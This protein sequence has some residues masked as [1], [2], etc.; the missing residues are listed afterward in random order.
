MASSNTGIP[1]SWPSETNPTTL[2]DASFSSYLNSTEENFICTLV[3]TTHNLKSTEYNRPKLED[4]EI[5]VFRAEKYFNGEIDRE[6]NIKSAIYLQKDIKSRTEKIITG[7]SKLNFQPRTPSVHSETSWNSQN[8]LLR[9]VL[10]RPSRSK[11]NLRE[12]RLSFLSS[13]YCC[14]YKS[15]DVEDYGQFSS[16]HGSRSFNSSYDRGAITKTIKTSFDTAD[17]PR[18][19]K[20]KID[21]TNSDLFTFP[22]VSASGAHK[23]DTESDASSD[24]F[25]IECLSCTGDPVV[26]SRESRNDES[27]GY[28]PSEASVDWSV[29]TASA[30]DFTA[31]SDTEDQ[32]STLTSVTGGG[33]TDQES[34]SSEKKSRRVGVFGGCRSQKAVRIADNVYKTSASQRKSSEKCQKMRRFSECFSPVTKL[35]AQHGVNLRH[36]KTLS[37]E[38]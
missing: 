15:V 19:N 7:L 34:R 9:P 30:A 18:F 13:C 8:V 25:E 11:A 29:V 38:F 23:D 16:N 32:K 28:E 4:D 12:K 24:L 3:S 27:D 6:N 37:F 26:A 33:M 5:D 1:P 31:V 21:S 14:D 10:K 20:L 17:I 36:S 35:S 2:R 22:V